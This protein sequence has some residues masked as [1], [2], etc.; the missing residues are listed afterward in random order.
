MIERNTF[1]LKIE[2]GKWKIMGPAV[3]NLIRFSSI[4]Y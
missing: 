1:K 2:K 3:S 4:M